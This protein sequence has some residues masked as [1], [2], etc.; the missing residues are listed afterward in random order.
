MRE[1]KYNSIEA[2]NSNEQNNMWDLHPKIFTKN[3][4]RRNYFAF[5]LSDN[6]NDKTKLNWTKELR[7]YPYR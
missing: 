1:K 6:K 3:E 2:K 4:L 7:C 5:I